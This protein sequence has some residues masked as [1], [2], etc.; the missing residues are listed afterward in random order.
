[1]EKRAAT[2]VTRSWDIGW[3]GRVAVLAVAAVAG[4]ATPATAALMGYLVVMFC[5][6]VI[7]SRLSVR[8]SE[9]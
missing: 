5:L 9:R 4:V 6:G 7:G 2:G 3:D 1:M 8:T